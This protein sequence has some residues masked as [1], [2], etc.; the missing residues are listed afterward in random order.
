MTCTFRSLVNYR[1]SQFIK[2]QCLLL[3]RLNYSE[4]SLHSHKTISETHSSFN[5]SVEDRNNEIIKYSTKLVKTAII[6]SPNAGKSTLINTIVGRKVN[7][8]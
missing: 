7:L 6:G 8:L 5:T 2:P 3:L 1:N 4:G